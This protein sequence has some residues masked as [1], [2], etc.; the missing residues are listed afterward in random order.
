M[1]EILKEWVGYNGKMTEEKKPDGSTK[2]TKHNKIWAVAL[3]DTGHLYVRYGPAKHPLK[4]TEQ[5]IRPKR[6]CSEAEALSIAERLFEEK[7][8]EKLHQKGYEAISFATFPHDVPS[9]STWRMSDE[10]EEIIAPVHEA[11]TLPHEEIVKPLLSILNEVSQLVQE[12]PCTV[13]KKQHPRYLV[14]IGNGQL[15]GPAKVRSLLERTE[16]GQAWLYAPC[17]RQEQTLL[18]AETLELLATL[19]ETKTLPVCVFKEGTG[20]AFLGKEEHRKHVR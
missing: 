1:P 2:K 4:L 20:Q 11:V 5:I 10:P 12:A 16:Q 6:G 17:V 3:T 15:Y 18:H 14:D 8:Q 9:F 13:C 7:V 19:V